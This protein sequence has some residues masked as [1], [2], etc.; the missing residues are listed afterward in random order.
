M[1]WVTLFPPDEL[2]RLLHLPGGVVTMGWLCIGWP[3]E[4]PPSPG[5]ERS[6]WSR[7]SPLADVVLAERWP[8]EDDAAAPA[9]PP[10]HLRGPDQAAVIGVRDAA[11]TLLTPAGSLGALDR[12]V[13]KVLALGHA[14]APTG[15]LMLVG[16]DHPVCAHAVSAYD[17]GVT[18][19]VL[20][21]AVAGE[22]LGV[23]AARTAG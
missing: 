15:R 17:Q 20:E 11:D 5:L 4:R 10:S 9:A 12:A 7:R 18:R 3:D 1:G 16:A 21:A 2:A 6:G 8:D 23:V 19:D 13:D 14:D 22:A